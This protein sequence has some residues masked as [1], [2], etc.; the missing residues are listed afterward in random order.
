MG[1][2]ICFLTAR[3]LGVARRYVLSDRNP[4]LV[5]AFLLMRDRPDDLAAEIRRIGIPKTRDGYDEIFHGFNA[6]LDTR[7][8]PTQSARFVILTR[9]SFRGVLSFSMREGRALYHPD[10][11]RL[12][13]I[14]EMSS[15]GLQLLLI[16]YRQMCRALEGV[17]V[18]CRDF[19]EVEVGA[20][21]VAFFD[22]P[23]ADGVQERTLPGWKFTWEDHERLCRLAH[24]CADRGAHV[25][26]LYNSYPRVAAMYEDR[27]ERKSVRNHHMSGRKSPATPVQDMLFVAK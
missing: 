13:G 1:S 18:H 27:F 16:R 25:Y 14:N 23:Y 12:G 20:G 19:G 2:G 11:G 7:L 15:Y 10:D 6:N 22:P 24:E 9:V 3:R 5:D 8:C 26:V 4:Y 17:E 21:D